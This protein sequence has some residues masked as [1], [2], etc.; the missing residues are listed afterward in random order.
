MCSISVNGT[1]EEGLATLGGQQK[2]FEKKL[3]NLAK[4]ASVN[5][6]GALDSI[7]PLKGMPEDLRHTRRFKTGRTRVFFTGQH[8]DCHYRVFYVKTFKKGGVEDENNPRFQRRLIR[9]LT[10]P[11]EYRELI[12]GM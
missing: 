9:A 3:Y 6:K 10:E 5:Q 1:A 12:S 2:S 4:E 11:A 7:A 8:T